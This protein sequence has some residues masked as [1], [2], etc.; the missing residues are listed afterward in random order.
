MILRKES[1]GQKRMLTYYVVSY[2]LQV[3][4]Y[5]SRNKVDDKTLFFLFKVFLAPKY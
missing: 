5:R 1:V 2:C 3:F 4:T